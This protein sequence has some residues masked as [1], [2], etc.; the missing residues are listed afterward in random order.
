MIRLNENQDSKSKAELLKY[1]IENKYEIVFWYKGK[2]VSD[3]RNKKYFRQNWRFAQPAALGYSKASG[4][5]MLRAWQKKGVTNTV[6]PAWKTFLI[7]EM[8]NILVYDGANGVHY[9]T[10]NRPEGPNYNEFGD[11]KMYGIFAQ[12]DPKT[13]PGENKGK[14]EEPESGVTE[15]TEPAEP[16]QTEPEEIPGTTLK[17]PTKPTVAPTAPVQNNK[18]PVHFQKTKPEVEPEPE[19]L[20]QNDILKQDDLF[21]KRLKQNQDSYDEIE[22]SYSSG[23]LKW[24]NKIYG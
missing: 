2:K 12:L 23:F 24:I 8:K 19:E 18:K 20:D 22:E 21:L 7:D 10:F 5:L 14:S 11:L 6:T 15:P 1:A 16:Q 17:E 13:K 9:K 3:P 4:G